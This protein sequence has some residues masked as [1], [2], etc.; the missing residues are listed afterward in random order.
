MLAPTAI[1]ERNNDRREKS[2]IETKIDKL[3]YNAEKDITSKGGN[4]TDVLRKV[5]MVQVDLDGNV[6]LQGTQNVKVLINNKPSSLTAGSVADAM[7]NDSGGWNRE[8]GG[9]H[10][11]ECKKYDAEGTGGIINIITKKKLLPVLAAWSMQVQAHVPAIFSEMWIT[12]RDDWEP[13]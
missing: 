13:V 6:M 11:S 5:P 3:V 2:L 10:K 1:V 9:Y 4:A 12:E 8:G 7:K